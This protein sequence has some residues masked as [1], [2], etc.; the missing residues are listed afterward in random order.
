MHERSARQTVD[1]PPEEFEILGSDG[2]VWRA[3]RQHLGNGVYRTPDDPTTL[4]DLIDARI[5]RLQE[6]D[7]QEQIAEEFRGPGSRS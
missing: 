7:L 4:E 2:C 1:L 5:R 6:Q 3:F